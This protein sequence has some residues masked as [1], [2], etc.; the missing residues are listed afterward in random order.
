MDA[1]FDQTMPDQFGVIGLTDAIAA[2]F[3]RP[4]EA[5]MGSDGGFRTA[6]VAAATYGLATIL[7][8]QALRRAERRPA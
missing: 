5:L 6:C 8:L 1:L 7:I 4:F 3:L 2:P